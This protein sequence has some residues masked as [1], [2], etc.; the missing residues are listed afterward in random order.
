MIPFKSNA[1][2]QRKGHGRSEV[3][4]RLFHFFSL[5][6]EQFLVAYHT[7]SNVESTFSAMKRKLSDQVRSKTPTAQ[8][9]EMF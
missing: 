9:N 5:H 1:T 4:A 6:R 3:W 8:I 2:E 7:R